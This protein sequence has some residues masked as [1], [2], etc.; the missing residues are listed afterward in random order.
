MEA[1][2]QG[3]DGTKDCRQNCLGETVGECSPPSLPGNRVGICS[4][5]VVTAKLFSKADQVTLSSVVSTR[6]PVA[7]HPWQHLALSIFFIL[8]HFGWYVVIDMILRTII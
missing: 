1:F 7:P 2:R 3:N 8:S 5:L 4:A 6:I